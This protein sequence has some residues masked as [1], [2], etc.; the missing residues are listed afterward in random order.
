M[1]NASGAVVWRAANAAFD[2]GVITDSI[3][4]MNVGFPGQYFDSES[5]LYYNWNRYYDATVGRYT[6][7]DPIG[8]DGGINTYAYVGGNPIS[9]FDREGMAPRSAAYEYPMLGGGG[10]G[11]VGRSVQAPTT[12]VYLGW[13]GGKPVYAGITRQSLSARSSQHGDRFNFLQPVGQCR[14]TND[15]ARGIEQALIN[16]N[17]QFQNINNSIAPSRGWYDDATSFGEQFL[18]GLGL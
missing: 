2:R 1:S 15:Q 5:G 12:Q 3:G 16:R 4:G 14:V 8:L 11:F 18:R 13:Q 7:S 17:P 10:G 9:F 6:Q